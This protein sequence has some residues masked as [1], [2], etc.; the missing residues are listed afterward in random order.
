MRI[1]QGRVSQRPHVRP[2]SEGTF[3]HNG[4][5]FNGNRFTTTLAKLGAR[6]TFIRSGRPPTNGHVE[7]LHRTILE[8]CWRPPFARF[9]QPR[10][11]GL[12]RELDA[13]ID[14]YNFHRAH[15]GRITQGRAP[16]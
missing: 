5:E 15:T 1:T 13:Y 3:S 12:E 14:I 7:R 11:R 8:E 4:N 10:Y 2:R 6:H 16:A 9:L